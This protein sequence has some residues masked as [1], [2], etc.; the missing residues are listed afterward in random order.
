MRTSRAVMLSVRHLIGQPTQWCRSRLRTFV[1][2]AHELLII[3]PLY[4]L[5]SGALTMRGAIILRDGKVSRLYQ[6]KSMFQPLIG[7]FSLTGMRFAER[8]S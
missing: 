3:M 7:L 6:V 1:G 2:D 8:I 5:A 4:H